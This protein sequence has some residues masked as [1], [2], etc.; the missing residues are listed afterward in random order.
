MKRS[1]LPLFLALLP[2]PLFAQASPHGTFFTA[3]YGSGGTWNLYQASSTPKTW[4]QA[5]EQSEATIDPLGNSG[6]KG[7]LVTVGSAAENMFVYTK[8]QG[9]FIWLGLTDNEKWGGKEA[10]LNRKGGWHWVTGEPLNYMLWSGNEPDEQEGPGREDGVAQE[11]GGRWR[12]F[13]IEEHGENSAMHAFMTEWETQSKDPVPGAIRIGPILPQKWASDLGSWKGK[14]TG[15]GP[16]TAFSVVGIDGVSIEN[17]TFE[18]Q[19]GLESMTEAYRIPRLNYHIDPNNPYG[20]GWAEVKDS[21]PFPMTQSGCGALQVATVRLEKA[22]TWSFNVHGDDFFAVRFPGLK[23]KSVTGMGGID[24]QDPSTIYHGCECGDGCMVGVIDLPAGESRIE[25]M[26][27]NRFND[28]MIQLLAA[29]GEMTMDGGTDQWRFPGHKATGDLAWPG[30]DA[31][32][33]KVTRTD[34]SAETPAMQNLMDGLALAATGTGKTEEGVA[35]INYARP[36]SAGDIEF[37][38]PAD[39]PGARLGVQPQFVVKATGNLVIPRDGVYHI[40][41]HGEERCALRIL[42]QKWTRL[43]RD[44][45]YRG[46]V[47]G[48]TMYG[49]Q[50]AFMGT[51][52]Q[53]FGEVTLKKGVYPVEALYLNAGK[54][55]TFCIFGGPAGFAPRL[56]VKDGAKIEPDHDGLPLVE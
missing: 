19:R 11:Y 46:K 38:D 29:P 31:A 4:T 37:P 3:P 18:I 21:P 48:D 33:W 40:G 32:G 23:W 5:Q 26:L 47:E 25:V 56:L 1:L 22:G 43:V 10:G 8:V 39:F 42:G 53:F 50:P 17:I 41:I 7:H 28:G 51:N 14:I 35:K 55:S 12:D 49:E 27:G 24:P 20:A 16:W 52:A 2:L 9:R 6:Q 36:D 15:K 30:V 13:S 44:T 45:S 34:R 54:V